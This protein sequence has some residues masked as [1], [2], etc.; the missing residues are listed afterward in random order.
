MKGAFE[1]T[2]PDSKADIKSIFRIS[3]DLVYN[4]SDCR[5]FNVEFPILNLKYVLFYY[6]DTRFI[7]TIGKIR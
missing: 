3:E 2:V 7:W 4:A 1:F 6:V 5:A